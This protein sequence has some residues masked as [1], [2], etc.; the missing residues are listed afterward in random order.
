M[1][2]TITLLTMAL[3]VAAVPARVEANPALVIPAVIVGGLVLTA[4]TANARAYAYTRGDSVYVQPRVAARCQVMRER[5]PTG[6]RKI[7]IC[8]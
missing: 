5:T 4:N 1:W 6:W 8:H 2:R 7:E 3:A